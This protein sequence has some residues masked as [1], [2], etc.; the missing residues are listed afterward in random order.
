MEIRII[1]S[2][3]LERKLK[4][5]KKD[6]GR[7]ILKAF[8]KIKK[9]GLNAI[10]ILKIHENYILGEIKYKKPPYRLYVIVD[11]KEKIFLLVDW[12]HKENQEKIIRILLKNLKH[13]IYEILEK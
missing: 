6:H 13:G 4:S 9:M 11:Q 8:R 1:I 10:K 12:E 2:P 5:L 7:L 3:N